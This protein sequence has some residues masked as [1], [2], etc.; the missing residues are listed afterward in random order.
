MEP[1]K[2]KDRKEEV[3]R[4]FDEMGWEDVDRID[5]WDGS[6][7]EQ[8]REVLTEEEFDSLLEELDDFEEL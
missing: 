6:D 7:I 2:Q 5:E 4:L 8:L 1:T 3:E